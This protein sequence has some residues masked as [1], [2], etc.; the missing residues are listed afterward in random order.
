MTEVTLFTR[1]DCVTRTKPNILIIERGLLP[2]D[3]SLVKHVHYAVL[4]F[5]LRKYY[6]RII[7]NRNKDRFVKRQLLCSN[8]QSAKLIL[9]FS[10]AERDLLLAKDEFILSKTNISPEVSIYVFH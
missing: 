1:Q 4:R 7:D 10:T 6:T 8:L 9:S 5:T 2:T 3:L